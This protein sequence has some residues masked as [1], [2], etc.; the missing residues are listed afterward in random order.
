[1]KLSLDK[2]NSYVERMHNLMLLKQP[3]VTWNIILSMPKGQ[4]VTILLLHQCCI[5]GTAQVLREM[6]FRIHL[7]IT[8]P[9]E[10]CRN[11]ELNSDLGEHSEYDKRS[12]LS[13]RERRPYRKTD[14]ARSSKKKTN[15]RRTLFDETTNDSESDIS[16]LLSTRRDFR[17]AERHSKVIKIL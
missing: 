7:K 1:M 2:V 17:E 8:F 13:E 3:R 15:A 11:S 5:S 14:R 10:Y 16:D 4:L 12:V 6:L 9:N